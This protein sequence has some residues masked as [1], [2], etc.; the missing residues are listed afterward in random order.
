MGRILSQINANYG[1]DY[2]V[3]AVYKFASKRK[4]RA[5]SLPFFFNHL[6]LNFIVK[7]HFAMPAL[8]LR[9]SENAAH[10]NVSDF[11]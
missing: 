1:G 6:Y 4:K 11:S 10:F 3:P 7:R 9:H 5:S 8:A 2:F